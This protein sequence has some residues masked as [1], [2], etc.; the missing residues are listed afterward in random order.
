MTQPRQDVEKLLHPDSV[1]F[2]GRVD[3]AAPD[4]FLGPLRI[5]FGDR[6]QLVDPAGGTIQ[7]LSI[8]RSLAEVPGGLDVAVID[9]PASEVSPW[10]RACG[11]RRVSS[12]V[13][14]TGFAG[15]GEKA[16]QLERELVAIATGAGMRLCGPNGSL[17]LYEPMP[18]PVSPDLRKVGLITQSGHMGRVMIQAAR[19]GIAFSR[20]IPTGNEADL[21]A[22][23]FI[24]YLAFDRDTAVIAG[25]FEGFR[26]GAKLRRAL[27]AAVSQDKPVVVVKVGRHQAAARMAVTHSAHLT[28][29]DAAVD[30]LFRQYGVVRVDDVDELLETAALFAKTPGGIHGPGVALYGISGGAVALMADQAQDNQIT[31]PELAAG[32]QEQLHRILPA[33]LGVANP[34]DPGNLYR[35]GSPAD[36]KEVLDIIGNDAA[37]DV[38]VCAMSGVI[39]GITDDFVSDIIAFRDSV[40]K[41][42][43]ATWNT[44]DLE[45]PAY[46]AL[47]K[48]GIPIFRS[49]RGCFGALH[50]LFERQRRHHVITSRD[51][52]PPPSP[53]H[54]STSRQLGPREAGELLRGIGLRIA[55]ESFVKSAAEAALAAHDIG[56]PVVLKAFVPQAFHKSDLGLVRVNLFTPEEVRDAFD[57]LAGL[58]AALP[59]GDA[60]EF[61]VQEQIAAG[62]ELIFGIVSDPT[63]GP[64]LLLGS[65]GLFTEIVR[66]VSVRPLPVTRLDV[67]EMLH[68]L[69]CYPL[70]TGARGRPVA[71][72]DQV[73]D[74]GCRLAAAA[75]DPVNRILELDLNPVIVGPTSVI[76]VDSVVIVAS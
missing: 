58:A 16:A 74:F 26:D 41:A 8:A 14:V 45:T 28:G 67:D 11:E 32:T 35:T 73:V 6:F 65:G 36:R 3:H 46:A 44:W 59:D 71:N 7:G 21:E 40:N 29:L 23:D 57:E 55:S 43:V 61:Q 50:A 9:V 52:S 25:Y 10:V 53:L 68:E 15:L 27:G 38:V 34:I 30:G 76:A 60:A 51:Q 18:E 1:A 75:A 4:R 22:A 24:E 39:K 69:A 72:L 20:W 5:R 66:D 12:L 2:I 19:H 70:L 49:F 48:S 64:C 56:P 47:V 63:A 17:N 13:V 33:D 54:A 31:V 62:T 42:V 37:I